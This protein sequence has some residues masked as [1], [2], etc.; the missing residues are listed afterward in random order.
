MPPIRIPPPS[1]Q[2]KVIEP[3]LQYNINFQSTSLWPPW[4]AVVTQTLSF[5]TKSSGK[6]NSGNAMFRW[7]STITSKANA[8]ATILRSTPEE[9]DHL[10]QRLKNE[11]ELCQNPSI[12]RGTVQ[13]PKSSDPSLQVG[14]TVQ[15]FEQTTRLCMLS[16]QDLKTT[17]CL[18][19]LQ[20][21]SKPPWNLSGIEKAD[22][23][24][25]ESEKKVTTC[26]SPRESR[27]RSPDYLRNRQ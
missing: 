27:T 25:L 5:P 12:I 21:P 13:S 9:T 20:P 19:K 10:L 1:S 4:C 8:F 3:Q 15:C 22:L 6:A 11:S 23:N 24:L 16:I 18:A 14:S 7:M 2:L 26:Q 17:D